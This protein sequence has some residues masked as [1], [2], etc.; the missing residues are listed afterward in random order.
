MKWP[1]TRRRETTAQLRDAEAR[2]DTVHQE[3]VRPLQKM[4]RENH[5]TDAIVADIRRRLKENT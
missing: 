4:R 5:L 1:W 3:V 2:A